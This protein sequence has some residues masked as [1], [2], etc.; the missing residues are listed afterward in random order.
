MSSD[1]TS[2]VIVFAIERQGKKENIVNQVRTQAVDGIETAWAKARQSH[3]VQVRD[4][5]EIYSEWQPSKEDEAF[6]TRLFPK[7]KVSYS[8]DRPTD[9]N[10]AQVFAEVQR[11]IEASLQKDAQKQTSAETVLPILRN[12]DELTQAMVHRPLASKMALCLAYVKTTPEGRIGID[13][14]M[15][16]KLKGT[17]DALW[18]EAFSALTRGLQ[19]SVAKHQ[20]DQFF[21]V[22][23]G[24]GFAASALGLPDF[25]S[26]ATSWV[27][28]S[29]ITIA[30][31]DPNTLCLCAS[32]RPITHHLEEM[33]LNS[34]YQGAINLTPC[35][36][37]FDGKTL[38]IQMK[39]LNP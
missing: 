26:N 22:N 6:I 4:V 32:D 20:D 27:K 15:A 36:L 31:L 2:N 3:G 13:Y 7:V 5:K 21:M 10:W 18:N 39:R 16:A 24:E 8:F 33:V 38:S 12:A 29:R 37:L 34:P 14:V 35:L 11:I 25:F 23:R 19:V 9:G 28:S 30:I 17:P 1:P